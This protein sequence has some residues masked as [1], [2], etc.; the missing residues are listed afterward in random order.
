MTTLTWSK[1]VRL[2]ALKISFP[3]GYIVYPCFISLSKNSFI[4]GKYGFLNSSCRILCLFIEL[5]IPLI[6]MK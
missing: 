4:L 3:F 6:I 2:K 1:G 5:F